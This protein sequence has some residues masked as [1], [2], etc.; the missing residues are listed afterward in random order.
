MTKPPEDS[1]AEAIQILEYALHLRMYGERA[2]GG[3]ETWRQ[4]DQDCER[5]LRD[6][7][8]ARNA[9]FVGAVMPRVGGVPFRCECSANVFSHNEELDQFKCNGCGTVYQGART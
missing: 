3:D 5:F 8:A 4:F 2:P 7:F 1:L 6:Q 9:A